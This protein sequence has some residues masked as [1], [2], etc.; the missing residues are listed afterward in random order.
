[1]LTV[2]RRP[3]GLHRRAPMK[4][5][6]N[7]IVPRRSCHSAV[8]LISPSWITLDII[9][10]ENTPFGKVIYA[11]TWIRM[12]HQRKKQEYEIVKKPTRKNKSLTVPYV[13]I[14]S[15]KPTKPHKC[16]SMISSN[17]ELPTDTEHVLFFSEPIDTHCRGILLTFNGPIAKQPRREHADTKVKYCHGQQHSYSKTNSPNSLK[18][19]FSHRGQDN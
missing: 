14:K 6:G 5:P 8:L 12:I 1:M 7:A 13:D 10:P 18:V 11:W 3:S 19:L 9:V 17:A 15:H 16:L 2:L 4:T